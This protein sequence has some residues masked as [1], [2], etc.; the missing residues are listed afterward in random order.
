MFFELALLC[1]WL[2]IRSGLSTAQGVYTLKAFIRSGLFMRSGLLIPAHT[3]GKG[4]TG[5]AKDVEGAANGEVDF[6]IGE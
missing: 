3:V 5:A 6:A 1:S 2:F 4:D